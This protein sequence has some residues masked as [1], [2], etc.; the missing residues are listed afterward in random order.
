MK[1]FD[2]NHQTKKLKKVLCEICSCKDKETLHWHHIIP[3]TDPNCTDDWKNVII[4]CSNCHNKIH[5]NK[6]KIIGIYDSTNL[7]YKRIVV[8]EE[9]G[10]KNIDI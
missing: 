4:V 7:P 1:K 9:N 6:I 3:R 2:K 8:F 5:A 10:K